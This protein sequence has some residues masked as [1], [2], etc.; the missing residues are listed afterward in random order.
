VFKLIVRS[1]REL[2][3]QSYNNYRLKFGVQK[4]KSFFELTG[5]KAMSDELEQLYGDIDALEL[6][7][8][9]LLDQQHN[10]S[11]APFFMVYIYHRF[12]FL[13]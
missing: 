1:S 13:V 6:Y 2:R 5:D 11:V 10:K 8:G 12:D 9:L 7:P 3:I 4:C